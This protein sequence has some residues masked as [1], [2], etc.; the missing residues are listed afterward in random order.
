[1]LDSETENRTHDSVAHRAVQLAIG[2]ILRMSARPARP[3]DLEEFERCRAIVMADNNVVP[4]WRPN[5][6][7]DRRSGAAGG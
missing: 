1:M 2:R 5:W 4:G 7:R 6:Q 3:G